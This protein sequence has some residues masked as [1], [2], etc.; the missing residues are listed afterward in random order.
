ME[1]AKKT[2]SIFYFTPVTDTKTKITIVGL[3]YD[4]SEQSQKML[5]FFKPA[6]KFS[7]E[8]LNAA[9]KKQKSAKVN[10]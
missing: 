2:W 9:L 3:G 6:N 4:D 7:M 10:K 5:A 1:A 8:Q